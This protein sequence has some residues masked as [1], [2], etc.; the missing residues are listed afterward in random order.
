MK[1]TLT[2]LM[3]MLS[4]TLLCIGCAKK[5]L[6]ELIFIVTDGVYTM[7]PAGTEQVYA[8]YISFDTHKRTFEFSYDPLSSYFN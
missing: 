7:E 1:K 4:I 2:M 6:N 5:P 3:F 8:P